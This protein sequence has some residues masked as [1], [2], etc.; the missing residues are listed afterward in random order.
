MP[1][2]TNPPDHSVVE[3]DAHHERHRGLCH[4]HN[5]ESPGRRGVNDTDH[6]TQQPDATSGL[7]R[8]WG[9]PDRLYRAACF[10]GYEVAQR[11]TREVEHPGPKLDAL[12]GLH[13]RVLRTAAEV[14]LLTMNG[15]AA[16]AEARWRSLHEIAVVAHVLHAADVS[17]AGRYL[18]YADVEAWD[19]LRQYQQ[20]AERL[21][22][23][24]FSDEHVHAAKEA[25]T[26]VIEQ[27]GDEMAHPNGWAKP[28]FPSMKP[29]DRV[30]FSRLEQ[31]AGLS[32]LRPFYRLGSHHVHAGSRAAGLNLSQERGEPPLITV[33]ATVLA[34]IAEVSHG[35]LIS[36]MQVISNLVDEAL[37]Y[38]VDGIIELLVGLNFVQRYTDHAG[39]LY[40][41]AARS[42]KERG[43]IEHEVPDD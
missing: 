6:L 39:S 1:D 28:L 19:D 43:W 34:D 17:I 29:R 4:T 7:D 37:E 30:T 16:G 41:A 20:S 11:V 21:G 22:R 38:E 42:A 8:V 33:G 24:P 2:P 25:A 40:V 9:P 14:R 31:L 35:A 15:F 3:T 32:H 27:F 26:S 13:G 5:R 10:L 36:V 23:E 12:I 18:A